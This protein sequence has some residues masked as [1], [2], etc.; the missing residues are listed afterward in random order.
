MFPGYM[1]HT[2]VYLPGL[3][4]T[5]ATFL[6]ICMYLDLSAYVDRVSYD[7]DTGVFISTITGRHIG[8]KDRHGY[9]RFCF[10]GRSVGAHR[11]AWRIV[12]GRD[13]DGE[14]DHLNGD[15]SDNR[16]A[17]LRVADRSGQMQNAKTPSTNTSG[18]RGVSWCAYKKKW[19]AQLWKDQKNYKLGWFDSPI[20]AH[21]AYLKA[22]SSLHEYFP[23]LPDRG[24]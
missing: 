8:S 3:L 4:L 7:P 22:K 13:P 6:E 23:G 11:L 1:G 14:I 18:Y 12:H 15:P 17:N 21:Q 9:L 10:N 16:I 5:A 2:T 24:A 20:E 19:R